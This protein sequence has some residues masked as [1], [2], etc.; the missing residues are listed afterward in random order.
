MNQIS[1]KS[2]FRFLAIIS[3]GYVYLPVVS[4]NLPLPFRLS[5]FY[6]ILWIISVFLLKPKTLTTRGLLVVYI[7]YFSLTSIVLLNSELVYAVN[8]TVT[9]RWVF[10][11]ILSFFFPILIYQYFVSE[12]DY[13]GL[14]MV[15]KYSIFFIVATNI[16]SLYYLID[17]P[18]AARE[19]VGLAGEESFIIR[20]QGIADIHSIYGLALL[21]S[22]FVFITLSLYTMK[23]KATFFLYLILCFTTLLT[24][25]FAQFTIPF[26]LAL[27][28]FLVT[29]LPKKK[30]QYFI[31]ITVII[32]IGINPLV[33][34]LDEL[35]QI[36][37]SQEI[38][39][40]FSYLSNALKEN[41]MTLAYGPIYNESNRVYVFYEM[42]DNA[43]NNFL[44]GGGYAMNHN[45]WLD[46]LSLF[47]IWVLLIYFSLIYYQIRTNLKLFDEKYRSIYII[48]VSMLMILGLISNLGNYRFFMSFFVLIPSGFFFLLNN[49]KTL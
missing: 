15:F 35:G 5:L 2:L 22:S 32:I 28:S 34:I 48:S 19:L 16:L 37:N 7:L 9:H 41:D 4:L 29:L 17:N 26:I 14:S 47:G 45:Y 31:I 3:V 21:M 49:K 1:T 38:S 39:R 18:L 43:K 6:P 13:N 23:R 46:R 20:R 27:L 44:F 10:N 12:R 30:N 24:M 25:I 36:I 33:N 42:I 8:R 11:E 40:R